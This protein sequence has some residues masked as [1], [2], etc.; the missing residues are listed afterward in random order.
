MVNLPQ[1]FNY[2]GSH[3][4]YEGDIEATESG[5]YKFNLYYS[6]YITVTIDG[7][8]VVPNAGA[9][10]GT[11]TPTNSASTSKPDSVCPSR[12]SGSPTAP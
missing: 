1:D 7:K 4:E 12:S 3:V 9:L 10:P 11:P 2:S 5:E 6:G 8:E